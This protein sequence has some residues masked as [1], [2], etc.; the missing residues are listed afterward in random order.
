MNSLLK[1]SERIKVVNTV[2]DSLHALRDAN[3]IL[4]SKH[5]YTAARLRSISN[6]KFHIE[7]ELCLSETLANQLEELQCEDATEELI[8]FFEL[9][10]RDS[11]L[12]SYLLN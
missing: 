4:L 10:K 11:P 6:A 2:A 9:L 1:P 12:Q 5:S 7:Q 3:V 8:N